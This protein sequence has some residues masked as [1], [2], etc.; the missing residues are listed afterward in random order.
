MIIDKLKQQPDLDKKVSKILGALLIF[1]PLYYVVLFLSPSLLNLDFD[2][3]FYRSNFSYVI[4]VGILLASIALPYATKYSNRKKRYVIFAFIV[5]FLVLPL[6][7]LFET[8]IRVDW[9]F[10]K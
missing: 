7:V 9:S 4:M 1:Y 6:M 5:I 8:F 3:Y 2:P 10:G